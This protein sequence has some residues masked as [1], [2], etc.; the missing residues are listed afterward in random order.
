MKRIKMSDCATTYVAAGIVQS[1]VMN[2][3]SIVLWRNFL[4]R[5]RLA[6]SKEAE[7]DVKH[8]VSTN[9]HLLLHWDTKTLPDIPGGSDLVDRIAILITVGSLEQLFAVLKIDRGTGK[10]QPKV[11]ITKLDDWGINSL[12]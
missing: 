3:D 5:A 4:R 2:L 7:A 9:G 12:V 8:A 1:V 6:R 10:S 11:W